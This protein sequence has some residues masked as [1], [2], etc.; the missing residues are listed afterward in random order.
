MGG[1]VERKHYGWEGKQDTPLILDSPETIAATKF[2]ISLKPFDATDFFSTGQAEQQEAMRT[3][4]IAMAIVWSDSLFAL[5]N[6]PEGS[7]FGFAPIPGD[8]SLIGGGTFFVNRHSRNPKQAV[9]YVVHVMQRGAQVNHDPGP[10]IA[11]PIRL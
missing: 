9:E 7:K 1:G 8:K 4:N 2:Y 3:K 10:Y 5:A 6:S 11:P